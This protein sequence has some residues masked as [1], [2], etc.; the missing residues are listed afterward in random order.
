[1]PENVIAFWFSGSLVSFTA[2]MHQ[3][4]GSHCFSLTNN[5]VLSKFNW[6]G[7]DLNV[8]NKRPFK[9]LKICKAVKGK[10][11]RTIFLPVG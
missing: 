10:H 4:Y 1:M 6:K 9:N 11:E 5:A 2:L 7:F 8:G 3:L